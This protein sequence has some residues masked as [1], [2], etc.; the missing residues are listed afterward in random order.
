MASTSETG[1]AKNVAAF[2]TLI[3]YV[4]GFGTNYN[5]SKTVMKLPQLQQKLLEG[6]NSI[7]AVSTT[8]STLNKSINERVALFNEMKAYA[9]R[10][11]NNLKASEASKETLAD[12]ASIMRKLRGKRASSKPTAP[13]D[14]NLPTPK[15]NSTSRLSFDNMIEHYNNLLQIVNK[16]TSYSPN[17]AILS[18][19]TFESKIAE[20]VAKNNE[21]VQMQANSSNAR[22]TRNEVL[23]HPTTGIVA[24]ANDIK[25]YI[26]A[27]FGNTSQQYN[28]VKG[29][30]FRAAPM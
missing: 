1:H 21:V 24:V 13:T 26:K 15:V 30:T 27:L 6:T 10:V 12:A 29:I 16:E 11:L 19:T 7:N 9:L 17:E 23:Y 25:L 14:P 5:P 22:V 4:N 8:V 2:S 20:L 28:Q 18:S 3:T